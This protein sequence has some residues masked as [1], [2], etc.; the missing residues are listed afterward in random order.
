MVPEDRCVRW[1]LRITPRNTS[2]SGFI[3]YLLTLT[4][5][6]PFTVNSPDGDDFSDNNI[7]FDI[8]VE[9]LIMRSEEFANLTFEQ[10]V[11]GLFVTTESLLSQ[12]EG[13]EDEAPTDN[14]FDS[15]FNEGPIGDVR[16][17]GTVNGGGTIG[18][19]LVAHGLGEIYVGTS[20]GGGLVNGVMS[21]SGVSDEAD[22]T[23]LRE[24]STLSAVPTIKLGSKVWKSG[25]QIRP[26]LRSRPSSRRC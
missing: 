22:F 17:L 1:N 5:F 23:P 18:L 16:F 8:V 19:S 3:R 26:G 15:D 25:P 13:E 9:N 4:R 12:F 11:D 7:I 21:Y 10:D 20:D 2:N 14:Q 6:T 24:S